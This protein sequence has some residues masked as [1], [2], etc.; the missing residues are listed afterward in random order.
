M[1]SLHDSTWEAFLG[2]LKFSLFFPFL[3][4]LFRILIF[5]CLEKFCISVLYCLCSHCC[6]KIVDK[7]NIRME[8]FI[9][10][11]GWRPQ[12]ILV[13]LACQQLLRRQV[14]L[15]PQTGG[16]GRWVL[17]LLSLLHVPFGLGPQPVGGDTHLQGRPSLLRHRDRGV[18]P[19]WF[20]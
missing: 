6:N 9:L 12:S 18:I 15:H 13:W 11:R 8:G 10:A 4:N 1:V 16:E 14:T 3:K 2:S 20:W 7:S 5:L 17:C 19:R